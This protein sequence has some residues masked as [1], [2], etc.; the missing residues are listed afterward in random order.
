MRMPWQKPLK[1]LS[2][3]RM[4]FI[5]TM[6]VAVQF[7][8][9]NVSL[10]SA[11]LKTDEKPSTGVIND[12][13][14]KE[15]SAASAWDIGMQFRFR[16]EAKDAG[17]FPNRDFALNLDHSNSYFLFRTKAHLGWIPS[18]WIAFYIE[19]R[20]AHD[21]SDSRTVPE[22]DLFDLYQAYV[23]IG[24]PKKFPLVLKAGRQ[25][26]IYGDQRYIGNSDWINYGRSFDSIKL[27]FQSDDSWI[28]AFVGRPV[29]TN[30]GRF[31][32]ANH[33]DWFS[34]L[35]GST[36]LIL[37]W[38]DTDVFVLARN[39]GLRSA[40][41]GG[42]GPR[43]IYTVGTRWKSLPDRLRSWDYRFEAVGQFGSIVQ[44]G[45][46]LD[47]RAQALNASAGYTWKNVFGAPRLAAGYDF[48]SG[49]GN[50]GDNRNGTFEL[51]F[52]T[53]H[54]FYGNMDLLGLRNMH[55]PRIEGSFKPVKN[56]TLSAE[57][58]GFWL[59]NT[60]DFL[61]PESGT[62][63]NQN[64]YGQ[65]TGYSSHAGREFDLLMDW[66]IA[67]WT[68]MRLGYGHFFIG[69]YI[70]QSINAVSSSDGAEGADWFY[71]QFS[72]NF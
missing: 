7:F 61:Y 10:F 38:Q 62:G 23:R 58:L 16:S 2:V 43:D 21:V 18:K 28:D 6:L 34:G 39:V 56:V 63:R 25:E 35:Y 13:L 31:D 14:R 11:D 51:L 32:N 55:I 57:L 20:D 5:I 8:L 50:P 37:S 26:L 71:S 68:Q 17:S 9:L 3:Y 70:R 66:K 72:F 29:L 44:N 67:A 40:S 53:N 33:Y 69:E 48:G 27:H 15:F 49:D 36:P 30:D 1:S 24:D 4:K 46:R 45:K 65:H 42:C 59:A 22:N 60:A 47:H 41:V 12:L 52:G 19:G 54:R 64:G